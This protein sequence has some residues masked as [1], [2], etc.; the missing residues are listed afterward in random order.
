MKFLQRL[1][2]LYRVERCRLF[3]YAL[4]LLGDESLSEDAVQDV[5]R[6]LCES[7]VNARNL[8][9]FVYRSVRNR[10]LDLLRHESRRKDNSSAAKATSIYWRH[11][12][13]DTLPAG[14]TILSRERA[15]QIEKGLNSLE[16]QEREVIVLH[17]YS[18][19]TFDAVSKILDAPIGTVASRYR[20]A[21]G[22]LR[23][24]LKGEKSQ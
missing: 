19:L 15:R 21:L 6:R 5:F 20:R 17:I 4:S 11:H 10:A 12:A 2:S 14:D 18:G 1:E 16:E 23:D 13:F 9:S 8:R 22:K 24:K 3:T 7:P